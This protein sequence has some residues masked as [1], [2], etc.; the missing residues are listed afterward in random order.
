TG[1]LNGD[2]RRDLVAT[3][4]DGDAVS[5]LLRAAAGAMAATMTVASGDAQSAAINTAY[6][7]ALSVIVRDSGGQ[8]MAG[9]S[10]TF[11]LPVNGAS[12]SFAGGAQSA[13]V[14]TAASGVAT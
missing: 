11:T 7:T 6:A 5:V 1:D 14:S 4:M 8:P 13:T 9:T 10:V 3:A 2:G 12:A